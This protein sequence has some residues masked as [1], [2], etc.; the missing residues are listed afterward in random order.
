MAE[1]LAFP[2]K[3]QVPKEIEDRLRAVAK[4]YI[5]ILNDAMDIL[6]D[7][8][9]EFEGLELIHEAVARTYAKAL[10]DVIANMDEDSD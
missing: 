10:A 2:I 5:K 3:K 7:D 1:I 8:G 4:E 9:S 6:I